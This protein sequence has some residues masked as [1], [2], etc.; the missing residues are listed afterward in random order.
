MRL[1]E[2]AN[3]F[4]SH[5]RHE[6]TL[7]EHT[8]RAYAIDLTEFQRF[9]K[10]E[11][12]IQTC[13]HELIRNYLRYLFE[14][15]GLKETSVKRRIA[16]LKTMFGWLET[17]MILEKNPF[18]RLSLKIK[19]P[20]RLP[21]ALTRIELSSLLINPIKILGFTSRK[22]YASEAFIQAASS[23]QGFIQLTTL[24][25]LELLFATGARVGELTQILIPDINL[26]EGIIK[27][28]GKG[29][30]ER[31]VFLPD[32]PI[33]ALIRVY[34]NI[35]TKFSPVTKILL[36]NT[37]GTPASTQLIRLLV[38]RA[39]ERARLTRRMTPHMLRHSAATYLLNAGVDIR[40]VQRLLG[41][42]SI[43]TTQ[44]YTHVSDSQLRLAICKAHPIG[45][46]VGK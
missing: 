29:N 27:I 10:N 24:L 34:N 31:Q 9:A 39:G 42:R 36:I 15:R 4:L 11:Y 22:A 19:L 12:T 41:H 23:R 33:H 13:D 6:K 38:R 8:L 28:K 30:R 46:I 21:R 18:H 16:C 5:C 2:T 43:T 14:E 40:Y 32:E 35:R 17:E 45:K 26:D 25:S 37:R 44:I 20:A 1:N 3:K 7:S